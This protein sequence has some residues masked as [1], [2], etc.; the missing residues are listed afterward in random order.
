MTA[1]MRGFTLE[2][3][4]FSDPSKG[5]SM[6]REDVL[7]ILVQKVLYVSLYCITTDLCSSRCNFLWLSIV[8]QAERPCSSAGHKHASSDRVALPLWRLATGNSYRMANKGLT[9]E[10]LRANAGSFTSR[11]SNSSRCLTYQHQLSVGTIHCFT[12]YADAHRC[13]V[14]RVLPRAEIG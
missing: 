5:K 12:R 9:L 1:D 6:S 4:S 13:V 7:L 10:T 2:R 3:G 11:L 14:L 8:L